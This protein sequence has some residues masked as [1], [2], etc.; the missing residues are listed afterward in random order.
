MNQGKPPEIL[1]EGRRLIFEF[2]KDKKRIR[3]NHEAEHRELYSLAA[4]A[5]REIMDDDAY[6]SSWR[7]G[8]EKRAA[9]RPLLRSLEVKALTEFHS[10]ERKIAESLS[11]RRPSRRR[12]AS[13]KKK[14]KSASR[15]RSPRKK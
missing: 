3:L 2:S 11:Y 10:V 7:N 5:I 13:K 6:L 1:P 9:L 12:R 4:R 8:S 14:K 15:E